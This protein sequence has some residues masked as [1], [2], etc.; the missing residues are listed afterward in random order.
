MWSYT[1][2][3][4]HSFPCTKHHDVLSSKATILLPLR[5]LCS[6][7]LAVSPITFSFSQSSVSN[8]LKKI[9]EKFK[10]MFLR[11]GEQTM[12]DSQEKSLLLASV[13]LLSVLHLLWY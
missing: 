12:L 7:W 6:L 5:H 2:A 3:R 8:L 10:R 1:S 13:R 4:Q 9:K 11:E